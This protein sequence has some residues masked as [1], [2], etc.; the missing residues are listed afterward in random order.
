[1]T[2]MSIKENLKPFFSTMGIMAS[3]THF[4]F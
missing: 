2:D 4:F 3:F 1:M